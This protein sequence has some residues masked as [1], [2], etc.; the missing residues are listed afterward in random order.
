MVARLGCGHQRLLVDAGIS[1]TD[2]LLSIH[3][4]IHSFISSLHPLI[5]S[6]HSSIHPSVIHLPLHSFISQFTFP[7]SHQLFHQF[8]N[9]SI[10]STSPSIHPLLHPFIHFS[11]HSS[12]SP[13]F[14]PLLH[15]F[16]HSPIPQTP[17]NPPPKRHQAMPPTWTG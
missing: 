4:F 2:T 7:S 6:F 8:I 9:F 10:N 11:I 17:S 5:H 13:S 3:P 14:H 15:P 1:V 12:T 16:I